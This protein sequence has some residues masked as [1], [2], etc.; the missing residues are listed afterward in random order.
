MEVSLPIIYMYTHT[1]VLARCKRPALYPYKDLIRY[2][3]VV[4]GKG[5]I[6]IRI[7]SKIGG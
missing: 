6:C 2:M 7:F 5:S 3:Y 4:M 1:V